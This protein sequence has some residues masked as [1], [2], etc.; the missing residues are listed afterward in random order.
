MS[1][2]NIKDRFKRD[3]TIKEYLALKKRI[4]RNLQKKAR[5]F[6]N[7]KEI[8]KSF[9]PVVRSTAESTVAITKELVPIREQIEELN[10]LMKPKAVRAGRKRPAEEE[11][12]EED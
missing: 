4:N 9:E 10:K 6:T 7:Y 11:E 3:K 1:F 12:S 8:E 5:D 2:L